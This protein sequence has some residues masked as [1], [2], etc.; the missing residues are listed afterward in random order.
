MVALAEHQCT[1]C[2]GGTAPLSHEEA[3]KLSEQAPGWDIHDDNIEKTFKFTNFVE[4]MKFAN[5]I[6]KIAEEQNHHPDLHISWG[7][8][9]VQYSTHAIGGISVNDF[10]M[11]AKINKIMDDYN[12]QAQSI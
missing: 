9:R 6:T 11:A 10:I 3:L 12:M 1:P 2:K 8:V 4:A 7:K 5:R